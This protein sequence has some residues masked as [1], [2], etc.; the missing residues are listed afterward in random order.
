M[1]LS[2]SKWL[3]AWIGCATAL[4]VSLSAIYLPVWGA[5]LFSPFCVASAVISARRD[6]LLIA[7]DAVT[8]LRFSVS[9]LDFQCKDGAWREGTVLPSTF[10]SR[11]LSIVAL[12]VAPAARPKYIVLMPDM[13]NSEVARRLRIRLR[14]AKDKDAATPVK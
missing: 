8:R 13:L 11:W 10:V 14:W 3:C 6:A 2:P 9:G 1:P 4:V 7:P 12:G 5:I